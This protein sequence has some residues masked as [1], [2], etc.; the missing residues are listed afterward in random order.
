MTIFQR[1]LFSVSITAVWCLLMPPYLY[2]ILG[3]PVAFVSSFFIGKQLPKTNEVFKERFKI[4]H[5]LVAVIIFYMLG[6]EFYDQWRLSSK[7]ATVANIFRVDVKR[8]MLLA[9]VGGSLVGAYSILYFI[10]VL[11]KAELTE[12]AKLSEPVGRFTWKDAA[13]A[14]VLSLAFGMRI[15]FYP[16]SGALPGTDGSA[17]WYVGKM[18]RDGAVLY[19][20]IFEHKGIFLYLIDAIGLSLTGGS[21]IGIWILEIINMF[22]TSC[23]MLMTTKL[24]TKKSGIQYLTTASLVA[25]IT[26]CMLMTDGNLSEEWVLPWIMMAVYI[27]YK[28]CVTN[29]YRFYDIVLLGISCGFIIFVRANMVAVFAAFLPIILYKMIKEKKWNDVGICALNFILGLS[30]IIVP[31][32]IYCVM[33]NSLEAMWRCYF[34]FSFAYSG[35]PAMSIPEVMWLLFRRMTIFSVLLVAAA[36]LFYKDKLFQINLWFYVVSLLL[37]S[38]S[39][40]PHA[41][42][43]MILIPALVLPLTWLLDAIRGVRVKRL[44]WILLLLTAIF[45]FVEFGMSVLTYHEPQKSEIAQYL[46]ENTEDDD[47]VLMM[48]NNCVYY[49]ESNRT[50][51]NRFFYQTPPINVSDELYGE[52]IEEL[53][54]TL[55]EA[56]VVVGDMKAQMEEEDNLS[57]AYQLLDTWC[58]NRVYSCEVYDSFRVYRNN[59]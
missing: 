32:I 50:T 9:I 39:G 29:S 38:M 44:D 42:Y 28:Y 53:E 11:G 20:D 52:F 14:I 36:R 58:E 10:G 12:K 23:F 2:G 26:I 1:F 35:K 6:T 7:I 18:L 22:A 4:W 31:I 49:Y 19:V 5:I 17:Y 8:L 15:A 24:F 47:N 27:C 34:E 48:G 56:I 51:T 30:V 46:L 54:Q 41:H 33:T 37:A 55:P 40:R 25:S 59:Q 57:K 45:F 16:W 43:A 21:T 3:I 13:F